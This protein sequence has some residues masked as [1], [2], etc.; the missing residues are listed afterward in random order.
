MLLRS[1]RVSKI[2]ALGKT[3]CFAER[4]EISWSSCIGHWCQ[5]RINKAL[6]FRL[7]FQLTGKIVLVRDAMSQ[8][9]PLLLVFESSVGFIGTFLSNCSSTRIHT[10]TICS[11]F[12]SKCKIILVH[13][14]FF[15]A[16]MKVFMGFKCYLLQRSFSRQFFCGMNSSTPIA[17]IYV[18]I[19]STC[20]VCM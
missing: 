20:N 13:L 11:L 18:H 3:S 9:C 17:S 7:G 14:F 15:L 19:C 2:T 8:H 4:Q 6:P 16:C 5:F 10:N 1:L 12:Y